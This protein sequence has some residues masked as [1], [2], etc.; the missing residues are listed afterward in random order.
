M[1]RRFAAG[2]CRKGGK[3]KIVELGMVRHD[4]GDRFGKCDSNL[5]VELDMV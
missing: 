3:E 4:C 1:R 2:V 5:S